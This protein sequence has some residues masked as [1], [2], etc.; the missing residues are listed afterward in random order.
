MALRHLSFGTN[1][2]NGHTANPTK[3]N[4]GAD[5]PSPTITRQTGQ[6]ERQ[7]SCQQQ[8]EQLRHTLPNGHSFKA[9]LPAAAVAGTSI[10]CM[11]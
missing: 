8:N 6:P 4:A 11:A 9:L 3:H 2:P 10:R 1:A 7:H 5:T